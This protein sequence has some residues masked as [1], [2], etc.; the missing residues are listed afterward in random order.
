MNVDLDAGEAKSSSSSSSAPL[1]PP[2]TLST[3]TTLHSASTLFCLPASLTSLVHFIALEGGKQ[4][5]SS[6][7][8]LN[9]V[10]RHHRAAAQPPHP[11]DPPL[12][13]RVMEYW[14]THLRHHRSLTFYSTVPLPPSLP[15]LPPPPHAATNSPKA[16]Q[17]QAL[18]LTEDGVLLPPF[19]RL[20]LSP[21]DLS[22]PWEV[23]MRLHPSLTAVASAEVRREVLGWADSSHKPPPSL[24]SSLASNFAPRSSSFLRLC[25]S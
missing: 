21:A 25:P 11:R 15:P 12:D 3:L 6:S 10:H 4:G 16:H 8:L 17:S 9:L 5:T 20:P 18:Q 2:L 1:T 23:V 7:H 24:S 22:H 19:D 13:M 14:W